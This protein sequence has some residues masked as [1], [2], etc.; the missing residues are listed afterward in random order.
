MPGP[1]YLG[2]LLGVA[3]GAVLLGDYC[4]YLVAEVVLY[5][6]GPV[7]VVELAVALV[8][9]HHV[10]VVIYPAGYLCLP[11]WGAYL[12]VDLTGVLG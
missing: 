9:A 6:V 7:L 11:L 10:I 8:S 12:V 3:L 2:A 5:Y 1:A 4:Y